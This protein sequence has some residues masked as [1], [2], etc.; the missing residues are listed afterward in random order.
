MEQTS[1]LANIQIYE[2]SGSNQFVDTSFVLFFLAV[3][4]GQNSGNIRFDTLLLVI[5]LIAV[6]VFPYLLMRDED[7]S[8]GKWLTG[9]ASIVGFALLLGVLL[10][11]SVG[12]V[13]PEIFGFLPFTLLILTAMVSC[14]IQFHKF[15][16]FRLAK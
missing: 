15:F 4:V 7:I 6:A 13:F 1:S 9:R 8:L 10:D 2:K 11:Q 14:Y 16:K 5:A 3:D 12:V